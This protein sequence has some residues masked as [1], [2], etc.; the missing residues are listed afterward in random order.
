M[1]MAA[2]L[3]MWPG[4]FE[5]TFVPPS[6]GGS[7]WKLTDWPRDFWGENV[8]RVWTTTTDGRR[9]PA[10]PLLPMSLGLRCAKNG[11]APDKVKYGVFRHS[12]A[13][14]SKVNTVLRSTFSPLQVYGKIFQGRVTPKWIV[15]SGQKSNSSAIWWLSSLP[16]SLTHI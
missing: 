11:Y 9:R 13:S 8:W 16:A 12:A 5:Q 7:I 2:I 1:G 6:I 4:S 3:V 10:Y 15:R 14:N